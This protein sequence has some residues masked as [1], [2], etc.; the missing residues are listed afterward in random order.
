MK[1][2]DRVF[3]LELVEMSNITYP[4]GHE[5]TIIGDDD[6]RGFNLEDDEGHR[7]DETRMIH[8]LLELV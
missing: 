3:L 2:G 5:F 4:K 7:L 6:I 8:H 1:I